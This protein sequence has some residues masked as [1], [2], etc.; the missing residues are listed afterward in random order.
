MTALDTPDDV[1]RR[2]R[3][4]RDHPTGT[5][6]PVHW[7]LTA[8]LLGYPVWWLLGVA[9]IA[10]QVVAVVMAV[11]LL[12][13]RRLRLPGPLAVWLLF[14][15]WVAL[16]ATMLWVDAPGAV[17]GGS[18][19]GR[20]AVFAYRASWYLTVTVALVWVCSLSETELPRRR[21]RSGLSWL[22]IVTVTGGVAGLLAPTLDFPSLLE[23]LLPASLADNPFV[24]SLIHP[25]LADVQSVL[26]Y[27]GARPRAPFDYSN[28]WGAA[29]ALLLPFFVVTW[30][31]D[32]SRRRRLVGAVIL[33]VAVVPVVLSLNRGLWGSLVILGLLF[34]VL[35]G[36][37]GRP[38]LLLGAAVAALLAAV[39]VAASPLG[40]VLSER[41]ASPHSN[42]RRGQLLEQ[43]VSSAVAGSP[44]LGFGSTR[45][46]QGSFS[47]IAG[48]ATV[49]CSAC[50]VPPLGT[51]GQLWLVIFTTGLVGA[52]L[53]LTWLV[54]LL[55]TCWRATTTNQTLCLAVLVAF[56]AQLA[57][58]DTLG[59]P[60]FTVMLAA[61]LVL[62]DRLDAA[63]TDPGRLL[64]R[65]VRRQTPLLAA[66]VLVGLLGGA[67]LTLVPAPVVYAART[68]VLL[69]GPPIALTTGDVAAAAAGLTVPNEPAR[70]STI[71]TESVLVLSDETMMRA[72]SGDRDAAAA[73]RA[74]TAVSAPSR[75]EVL[76]VTVEADSADEA[77]TG[78]SRVVDSYLLTRAD[79]LEE[80]R[81]QAIT[82]I[83]AQLDAEVTRPV[84]PSLD[85]SDSA[86]VETSLQGALGSLALTGTEA[87]QLLRA[88]EAVE[89]RRQREIPIFSGAA[90]GLL[91]GALVAAW[92]ERSAGA[93]RR[94]RGPTSTPEA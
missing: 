52:A 63:P 68:A 48:G 15:A 92:R 8:L 50:S 69:E 88:S 71:D 83:R 70:Q 43:T 7:P 12:R 21:V 60:L 16:S 64:A 11:Q 5:G 56:I 65:A 86:T 93:R 37:R 66:F 59:V 91:A 74:R 77:E 4:P 94:V 41:I 25:G 81:N 19:T 85:P 3:E 51:Q 35:L 57:V 36:R 54:L 44:V 33:A 89:V 58:Y 45:D 67:A 2:H 26:G 49:D 90:L 32:G 10:P 9:W 23:L 20:L 75:T 82:R 17:A 24:A 31:R 18:G 29:L 61:G 73:L 80:R 76:I 14:L 28:T 62:R 38:G 55:S 1:S 72:T 87:G 27:E 84:D 13:R 34:L 30:L 47:S 6:W 39:L 46:V 79:Y 40:Q 42:E 22:F 53:F 78:A